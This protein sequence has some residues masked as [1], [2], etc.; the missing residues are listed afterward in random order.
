MKRTASN[1]INGRQHENTIT[2]TPKL[3]K[4]TQVSELYNVSLSWLRNARWKGDGFPFIKIGGGV[5]YRPEDIDTF[6]S[7]RLMHSTSEY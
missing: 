7:S 3:Y 5:F 4:E 2:N 6:I 1:D